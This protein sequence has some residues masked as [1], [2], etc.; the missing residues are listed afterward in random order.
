MARYRTG[1][2]R[3]H[4]G[5]VERTQK[6]QLVGRHGAGS[7]WPAIRRTRRRRLRH[8]EYRPIQN[9]ILRLFG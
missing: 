1:V 9:F 8:R 4:K 6:W 5:G 3:K 7:V 2:R